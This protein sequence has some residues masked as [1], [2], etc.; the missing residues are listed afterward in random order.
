MA[1]TGDFDTFYVYAGGPECII[2]T[3]YV[4]TGDCEIAYCGGPDVILGT[5]G[6]GGEPPGGETVPGLFFANG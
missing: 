3:D 6:G 4:G 1:K 2:D 5:G